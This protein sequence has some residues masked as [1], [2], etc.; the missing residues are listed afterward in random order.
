MSILR[1]LN[2]WPG[3]ENAGGALFFDWFE[4]CVESRVPGSAKLVL[5]GDSLAAGK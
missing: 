1:E 3:T 4:D 2:L 5:K